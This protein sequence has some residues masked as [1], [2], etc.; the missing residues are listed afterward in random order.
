MLEQAAIQTLQPSLNRTS[1]APSVSQQCDPIL[2]IFAS[3]FNPRSANI[4]AFQSPS[5]P[6]P[7]PLTRL[8]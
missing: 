6:T 4:P 8:T 5:V 3:S 7:L 1:K 2:P